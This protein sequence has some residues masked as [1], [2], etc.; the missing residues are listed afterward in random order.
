MNT[1]NSN[2][3]YTN[4]DYSAAI[5][6]YLS[7]KYS[8]EFKVDGLGGTYGTADNTTVKAWCHSVTGDYADIGFMAEI[9]KED[10]GVVKDKYLH[11]VSADMISRQLCNNRDDVAAYSVVESGAY[12]SATGIMDLN[13]YLRELDTYFVTTHFFVKDPKLTSVDEYTNMVLSV[14][15]IAKKLKLADV[16][17]IV[18]FVDEISADMEKTFKETSVDKLYDVFLMKDY[19]NCHATIQLIDDEIMTS[20]ESIQS[21]FEK[22]VK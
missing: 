22:G 7:G 3:S 14:G 21:S 1:S 17:I 19:V 9:S 18:W 10:L 6:K 15:E 4:A 16:C 11:I 2:A 20:R 5:E 8:A 13:T 12:S